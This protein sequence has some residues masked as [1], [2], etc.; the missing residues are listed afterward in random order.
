MKKNS[1]GTIPAVIG[2]IAVIGLIGL[3]LGGGKEKCSKP[4]CDEERESG[5]SYCFWHDYFSSGSS[6]S[7]G[8]SGSSSSSSYGNSGS[9]SSNYGSSSSSSSSSSSKYSGKRK[10][11]SKYS[12]SSKSSKSYKYDTYDDGYEDVYENEDYDTD[13]YN[14]DN[15][16]ANGVDDAM[17]DLEEEGELDW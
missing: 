17:D 13:R 15:D 9:S 5:S 6:S 3:A 16:Y 10:S 8:S 7:Y 4:G 12:S 14:K 1:L 2:V 11:S